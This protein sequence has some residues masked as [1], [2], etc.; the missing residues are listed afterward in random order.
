MYFIL[1]AFWLIVS[2]FVLAMFLQ[3]FFYWKT[4]NYSFKIAHI[5]YVL[6]FLLCV[7]IWVFLIPDPEFANRIQHAL[8]GGFI[9]VF[10]FYLSWLASGVKMT[11]IQFF[12]LSILVA[13][14]FW[15]A[16]E[17]AESLLQLQFWLRFSSYLED[18]WYD[19]WANGLGSLI[20]A[21]FF[22]FLT[23]K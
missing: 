7:M 13:T 21:S 15:V 17:F 22:T 16:N 23:K 10:L 12:F 19:L 18:T 1:Y 20:A 9:M 8:G 6:V 3:F 5:L 14:A 4:G 2:Y 11:K